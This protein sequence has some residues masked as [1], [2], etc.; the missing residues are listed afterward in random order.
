[1]VG[2][3]FWIVLTFGVAAIGSQFEPGDWYR[4]IAKPTWTPPGWVFGPVWGMLYLA[5]SISAWLIWRQ[6][7]IVRVTAPLAL[8]FAQLAANGLWSWLFFGRQ[9]IGAALVDLLVLLLLLVQ[10]T[11]MF[12]RIRKAAGIMMVAYL[13]WV[14]FATALNFQIWRLN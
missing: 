1:M 4:T 9:L 11:V 13:L 2:L 6:R 10:M 8:Y 12:M 5:M 14:S 3:A 7:A